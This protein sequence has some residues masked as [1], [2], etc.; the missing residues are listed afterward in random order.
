MSKGQTAASKQ[1]LSFSID[2]KKV[3]W[4]PESNKYLVAQPPMDQIIELIHEG[5]ENEVIV[6]RCNEVLEAA[7]EEAG[8]IIS[9]LRTYLDVNMDDHELKAKIKS[10]N[11]AFSP[12]SRVAV[13]FYRLN[14]TVFKVEYETKEAERLNHPKFAQFEIQ[15]AQ[16]FSHHFRVFHSGGWITLWVDGDVKGSWKE[17]E[18]HFVGGIFSMHIIQKIYKRDEEEWM[19]VFHAAGVT[20]GKNSLMFSGESGSGKSTLSALLLANGLDVL[21]DDFLP[22]DIEGMVCRFPSAISIKKQTYDLLSPIF[23]ELN[24]SPEFYNPAFDKTFRYLPAQKT[25]L[26]CAPCKALILVKYKE[27]SGFSLTEMSKTEAFTLLIPDSWISPEPENVR[28]F[29]DW[30]T[31]MP[32]YSLT[33][34]DNEKMVEEVKQMLSG[35]WNP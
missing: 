17:N 10:E 24:N 9:E 12:E 25:E 18:G 27:N 22:V 19:G 5:V 1:L 14:D 8:I 2:D 20:D 4:F 23:P 13:K 16:H 30:F 29:M 6:A 34:S 15:A 7:N 11:V 31:K 3:L 32:C 35:P 28:R 26:F 21:A 33:Y